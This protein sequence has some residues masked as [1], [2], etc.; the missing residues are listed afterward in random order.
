MAR[1]NTALRITEEER[2]RWEAAA[3][4]LGISRAA[5]IR[6]AANEKAMKV[7]RELSG[8]EAERPRKS[9]KGG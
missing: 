8:L 4:F 1:L 7:S 2:E 9:K 5:F 3:D 6:L